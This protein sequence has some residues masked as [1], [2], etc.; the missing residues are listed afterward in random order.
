VSKGTPVSLASSVSRSAVKSVSHV[1]GVLAALTLATAVQAQ[2]TPTLNLGLVTFL[3]GPAA[4]PFGIP[5][6][7]AAELVSE[8]INKGALPAPYDKKG[9]GGANVQLVIVDEAGSTTEVVQSFRNLVQRQNVNAVVGYISS[10]SCLAVA[11]VA[12]ELKMLT[13]FFDC[14]TP[15]IFE[16]AK[17]NYVFRTSA[18]STMDSVAAARY[19]K[20]KY[21]DTTSYAGLNQNYAWGQDSWKDFDESMKILLPNAKEATTQFPKLFAGQ[22]NAEISALLVSKANVIHSS[23]WGGDLESFIL[24]AGSRGLQK[25]SRLILTTGETT[26]FRLRGQIPNDVVLGARGP[27]GVLAHKSP[28]NDWF[29]QQYQDR[30]GTPPVYSAY[31][32]AQAIL[33]VKIAYD[34][35]ATGPDLPS[36][37][38][39]GKALTGLKYESFGT[40]VEMALGDGHQAVTETAYGTFNFNKST[41]TPE[42]NNVVY[43]SAWCVN[44]P[45]NVKSADW[46]KDGMKGAKCD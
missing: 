20:A 22:Y 3:S 30:Y 21:G 35:A 32:M 12:E 5:A 24:Q 43:Y 42:I 13:V 1:A 31:Q 9:M 15:R 41:D 8:A 45:P 19:V 23:F 27:Y 17:Y 36:T 44:P 26:M 11:P 29:R 33:G 46:I 34:K 14:G 16:D 2:T 25:E 4:G 7:N 18:T 40:T 6:R 38:A 28:L 37:D 39:V 10:G